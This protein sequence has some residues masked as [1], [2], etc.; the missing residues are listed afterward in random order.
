MKTQSIKYL[1]V[2]LGVAVVLNV[3]A[4]AGPGP[5]PRVQSRSFGV[6]KS[7]LAKV[8]APTIAFGGSK[9][10]PTLVAASGPHGSIYL[11]RW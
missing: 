11:Y 8:N 1:T 2:L 9:F 4:L 10:G 6:Q 5:Q 3:S 7:V